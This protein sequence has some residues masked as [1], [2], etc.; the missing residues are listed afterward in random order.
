MIGGF[1]CAG[2]SNGSLVKSWRR[3]NKEEGKDSERRA[4]VVAYAQQQEWPEGRCPVTGQSFEY[5]VL[6]FR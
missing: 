4:A 1:R 6:P 3:A 5:T 2:S